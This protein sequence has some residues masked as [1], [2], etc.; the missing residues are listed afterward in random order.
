MREKLSKTMEERGYDVISFADGASLL[1]YVR[2][3][4]PACIF[5]EARATD[6]SGL[7]L[8]KKLRAENCGAPVF[9]TSATGAISMAV[10]AVRNGAFDFIVKPFCS[11]E[12]ARRV[13]AAIDEYC[14]PASN[15]N[16]AGISL[17]VPGG[18]PLTEPRTRGAGADS[19]RRDQQ[20]NRAAVGLERADRRGLS[21]Q[22]HAQ[23][24]RQ[25]R[26][27]AAP[28]CLQPGPASLN[29]GCELTRSSR[30]PASFRRGPAA[31][32]PYGNPNRTGSFVAASHHQGW[33]DFRVAVLRTAQGGKP[34]RLIANASCH[35]QP[36]RGRGTCHRPGRGPPT[37]TPV[38]RSMP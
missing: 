35:D 13:E 3:R 17:H 25:E 22:H 31:H 36:G 4:T 19:R 24:R 21:G 2:A 7:D 11:R 15:D 37:W 18:Q 26:G 23:G 5:V 38:R 30:S 32:K 34:M 12:V 8:L 6:R 9:V 20:G 28:P 1:S 29:H 10:D 16:V 33:W 14:E 27:R